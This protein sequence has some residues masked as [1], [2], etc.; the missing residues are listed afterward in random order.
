MNKYAIKVDHI[1]KKFRIGGI[2]NPHRTLRDTITNSIRSP[3]KRMGKLLSGHASGATELNE[4]FWAL[5]NVSF[6]IKHGEAIGIIGNNGAG[7]STLLKILSRITDPTAGEAKI[8]GRMGSLLEVGTGFHPELTGRENIFLNGAILG[9][10]RQ[11]LVRKFDEIVAFAE[12]EKFI[13]TPIK[14][15]SSG[16]YIRLAF[17]VAAHLEPEILVIDE[18]LAVGDIRFQKKCLGKMEDVTKSGRTVLFVSHNMSAVRSLCQRGI[19]LNQGEIQKDGPI[20]I[21]LHEYL[22]SF[23]NTEQAAK[24]W[25]KDNRPGNSMIKMNSL[26]IIDNQGK[27][28]DQVNLSE[29]FMI[30]LDYDAVNDG[31]QVCF[32]LS[33]ISDDGICVF[34]SLNNLEKNFY[35]TPLKTGTYSSTCHIPG[36]L[37]N[38]G[39]FFIT[40]IGNSANWSDPFTLD[41]IVSF[42]AIDDGKLKADY[43]G[44]YGGYIRPMLTWKTEMAARV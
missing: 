37:L 20:D 9:M 4:T 14:H 11:E 8:Y 43:F 5:K 24:Y 40:L 28:T 34:S 12:I 29:D 10:R 23:Q 6:Q 21:V 30:K 42:E 2:K 18:V 39:Q 31:S 41:R 26:E 32:S 13:D 16:M 3:F 27:V 44:N 17:S 36:N 22:S 25:T 38:N 33:V 35:G 15:Y 1:S 19:L 7:K